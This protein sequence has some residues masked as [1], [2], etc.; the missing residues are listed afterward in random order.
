[1]SSCRFTVALPAEK[2]VAQEYEEDEASARW[3]GAP[4]D[5]TAAQ[6]SIGE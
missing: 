6:R 5:V 4:D 3:G 2:L 1:M